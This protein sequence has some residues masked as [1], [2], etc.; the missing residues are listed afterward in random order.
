MNMDL[1]TFI[2]EYNKR[3]DWNKD[4]LDKEYKPGDRIRSVIDAYLSM[5]K[6]TEED[7][8][9]STAEI[10]DCED[11]GK[12]YEEL[13]IFSNIDCHTMYFWLYPDENEESYKKRRVEII[14]ELISKRKAEISE[15]LRELNS[16][17]DELC[18]L[19]AAIG[20]VVQRKPTDDEINEKC[21]YLH[22]K[23][24]QYSVRIFKGSQLFASEPNYLG[25]YTHVAFLDPSV[26]KRIDK[27]KYYKCWY[28][29]TDASDPAD[30]SE[31]YFF[32]YV[33]Q[34]PDYIEDAIKA[35]NKIGKYVKS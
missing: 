15:K 11:D 16:E 26:Q 6:I 17:R 19:Y 14:N 1:K 30:S 28:S 21:G 18:G 3:I 33:E 31:Y 13:Q 10:F 32:V 35:G 23:L 20:N 29:Y 22:S 34:V 7:Y 9:Y 2:E 5:D 24:S 27:E 8:D 12:K 25:D 4:V